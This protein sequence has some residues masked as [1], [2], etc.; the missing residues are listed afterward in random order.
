MVILWVL[1]FGEKYKSAAINKRGVWFLTIFIFDF[2]I[3]IL[4]SVPIFFNVLPLKVINKSV[5]R[6]LQNLLKIYFG[7]DCL[8]RFNRKCLY[9]IIYFKM[10]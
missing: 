10:F 6:I 5:K 7:Y 4:F 1:V 9:S 3:R 2:P 8:N